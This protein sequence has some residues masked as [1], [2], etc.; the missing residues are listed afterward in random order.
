LSVNLPF[1]EFR[2]AIKCRLLICLSRSVDMKIS[3]ISDSLVV[4][5]ALRD[6]KNAVDE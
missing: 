4:R 2:G 1:N 5:I 6:E 3:V